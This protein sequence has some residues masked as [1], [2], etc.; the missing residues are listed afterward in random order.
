MEQFRATSL[1]FFGA[2]L[3]SATVLALG[4]LADHGGIATIPWCY[5]F[6]LGFTVVIGLPVF[7]VFRRMGIIRWWIAG[8]TGFLAGAIF[9]DVWGAA[10]GTVEGLI[11]WSIWRLGDAPGGKSAEAECRRP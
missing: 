7:L 4:M 10:A 9:A 3:A 11:F 5:A 2:P 1:A 6:T 8:L